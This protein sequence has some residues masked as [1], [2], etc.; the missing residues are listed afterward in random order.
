MSKVSNAGESSNGRK[1]VFE[2]VNVRSIR[3]SPSISKVCTQRK[4][5][6]E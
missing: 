3:T 1:A 5:F 4:E 2:T 6:K